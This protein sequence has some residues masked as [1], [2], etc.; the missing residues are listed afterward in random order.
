MHLDLE[1]CGVSRLGER[2]QVVI[3][4]EARKKLKLKKGEKLFVFC[5]DKDALVLIKA[6]SMKNL[7]T[8]AETEISKF[9]KIINR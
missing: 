4:V 6:A 8:K 7:L 2:G 1:C 9:T 3:P 5:R